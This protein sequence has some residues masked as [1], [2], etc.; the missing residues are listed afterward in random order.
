MMKV[1]SL[2]F[3]KVSIV[4]TAMMV[5]VQN[6]LYIAG[7]CDPGNIIV[8]I[9]STIVIVTL[10]VL[11]IGR[12]QSYYLQ[13]KK[14]RECTQKV[15]KGQLYN[16]ITDINEVDEI[17]KVSWDINDMLDQ[18]EAFA[19]DTDTSLKNAAEGKEYRRVLTNGLH[20]DFVSVGTNINSAIEEVVKAK[21]RDNFVLDKVVPIIKEYQN[22]NYTA[23]INSADIPVDMKELGDGVNSLGDSLSNLM[24]TNHRNGTTLQESSHTLSSSMQKILDGANTQANSLVDVRDVIS[25]VTEN[26]NST[27]QKSREMTNIA[28]TTKDKATLGNELAENTVKSMEQ[29][30]KSTESM[31]QA[32]ETI[33]QIA[34]QTNILSLNAAVEA[35]TAG[36]AGKG[37]AVVAQEVRVL[38]SKSAESADMIKKLVTEANDRTNEGKNN[39]QEMIANFTELNKLIEDTVVLV[40]EVANS[41]D[42]QKE[43]VDQ[44]NSTIGNLNKMTDDNKAIADETNKISDGLQYISDV[45]IKETET[46][47]YKGK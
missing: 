42:I 13:M 41:T 12:I 23:E 46:K 30:E 44:I 5:L 8:P 22:S 47:N 25:K 35:A 17:G 37:F 10:D 6:I 29:I 32:V 43:G 26:T 28:R 9:I 45:I 18:L 40:E 36:E 16:R 27:S 2:K 19:R 33:E 34:F 39:S 14:V 1:Q 21:V 15:A 38:A 31:T 4:V 20:G 11:A 7:F 24:L 3:I